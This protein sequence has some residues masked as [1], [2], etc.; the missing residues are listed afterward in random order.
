MKILAIDTSSNI[1]S[2]AILEDTN[3]IAE[4]NIESGRSND[5]MTIVK[6]LLDNNNLHLSDID[7]FA[8]SVG[9][10]SFTGVRIGVSTIKAFVDATDSF[11]VPISSL[12]G[13]A[14]NVPNS[15]LKNESNLVCTLIDCRNE[16]VY[17]GLFKRN[18]SEF[19]PITDFDAYPIDE[20]LK[21]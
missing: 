21:V 1:C 3:I 19:L 10:G 13:L 17:F 11:C 9:P 7:L 4:K 12:E 6:N 2:A 5:L 8:C 15:Y 14:Y 16:N 18:G 20:A